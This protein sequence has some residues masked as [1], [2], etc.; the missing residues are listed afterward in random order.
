MY[1]KNIN[2]RFD[3][4]REQKGPVSSVSEVEGGVTVAPVPV[5]FG[6]D[7]VVK[8]S[9]ILAQSGADGIFLHMGYGPLDHW[10]Y[11]TDL[12]LKKNGNSWEVTF[13]VKDDNRLNFCFRDSAGNWD[14]N[15]GKNW[16]FEVHNGKLI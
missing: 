15:N 11:V 1:R 4:D 7:I 6:E 10:N 9:G 12:P 2:S 5:T 16:S 14:N 8:Y 13:E 3:I